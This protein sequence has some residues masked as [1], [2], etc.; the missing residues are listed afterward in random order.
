MPRRAVFFAQY[1]QA[2]F[3]V[4]RTHSIVAF[5]LGVNMQPNS[6]AAI[7]KRFGTIGARVGVIWVFEVHTH[8]HVDVLLLGYAAARAAP[9]I[10]ERTVALVVLPS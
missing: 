7:G 3:D 2:V 4:L 8:A 9:P 5:K 6:A 1:A 10:D